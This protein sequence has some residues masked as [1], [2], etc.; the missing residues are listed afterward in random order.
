MLILENHKTHIGIRSASQ[1]EP[2]VTTHVFTPYVCIGFIAW[3]GSD[4]TMDLTDKVDLLS[5]TFV[6]SLIFC[7]IGW[8]ATFCS[9]REWLFVRSRRCSPV[10][11]DGSRAVFRKSKGRSV[12]NQ[13]FQTS[14]SFLSRMYIKTIPPRKLY[15]SKLTIWFYK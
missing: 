9:D 15:F 5:M 7:G 14:L 11:E 2:R 12:P 3:H 8:N 6:H 1:H 4:V 10:P 13:F